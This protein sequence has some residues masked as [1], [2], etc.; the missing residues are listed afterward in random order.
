ME[1]SGR[2]RCQSVGKRRPLQSVERSGHRSRGLQ[3]VL[4]GSFCIFPLAGPTLSPM[5]SICIMLGA[6]LGSVRP[7]TLDGAAAIQIPNATKA[8]AEDARE[9]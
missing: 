8:S 9:A 7:G 3:P 6:S 4:Y 2:D 1:P 5:L